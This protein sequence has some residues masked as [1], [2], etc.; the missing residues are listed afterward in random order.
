V[1]RA[2]PCIL[3]KLGAGAHDSDQHAPGFRKAKAWRT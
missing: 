3:P 1:E 2:V